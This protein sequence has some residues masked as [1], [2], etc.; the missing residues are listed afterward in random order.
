MSMFQ[1]VAQACLGRII[2]FKNKIYA[3][4]SFIFLIFDIALSWYLLHKSGYQYVKLLCPNV[5]IHYV[6]GISNANLIDGDGNF[7]RNNLKNLTR[8]VKK[9]GRGGGLL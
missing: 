7:A 4:F 2:F 1:R 5:S 6:H 9:E 3:S 8:R